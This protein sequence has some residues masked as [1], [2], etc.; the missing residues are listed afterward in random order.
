ME[1]W[2]NRNIDDDKSAKMPIFSFIRR[3][4]KCVCMLFLQINNYKFGLCFD[5]L[6]NKN[7][8]I[9]R[10]TILTWNRANF[11]V[12]GTGSFTSLRVKIDT[13]HY[14]GLS[15]CLS[16]CR[17]VFLSICNASVVCSITFNYPWYQCCPSQISIDFQGQDQTDGSH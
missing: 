7:Q 17:S 15:A 1:G 10:F 2:G 9:S 3:L 4:N 13:V 14:F 6:C 11:A 8:T 12:R 5:Y 16:L